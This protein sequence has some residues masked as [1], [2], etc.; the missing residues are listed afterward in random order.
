MTATLTLDN[1]QEKAEAEQVLSAME[2]AERATRQ[3]QYQHQRR[4]PPPTGPDW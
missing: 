4:S 2:R 1:V 3:G